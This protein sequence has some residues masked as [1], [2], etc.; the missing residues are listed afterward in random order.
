MHSP[1]DSTVSVS[2]ASRIFRA[3]KHP[4]SFIALEGSDHLLCAPGQAKRAARMISAWA[5]P[6]LPG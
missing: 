5:D 2:N 6:Y 1:T 4:R 3:A